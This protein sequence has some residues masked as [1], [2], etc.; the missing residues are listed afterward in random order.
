MVGSFFDNFPIFGSRLVKDDPNYVRT[1]AERK[2]RREKNMAGS[3]N[4]IVNSKGDFLD[5]ERFV[6][7]VEN[8]GDAYE[9]AEEL[10]G[11]IWWL[12]CMAQEAP[13]M[14]AEELVEHARRN[15]NVGLQLAKEQDKTG[16]IHGTI[17]EIGD[18][19]D[20]QP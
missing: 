6:Q 12:A 20:R 14:S 9:M 18:G 15:Y 10:F 8:L 16:M 2:A 13:V 17:P 7:R 19:N 4:H 5:N 1:S 11:M 3:Y